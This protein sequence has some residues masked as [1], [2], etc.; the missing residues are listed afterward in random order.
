MKHREKNITVLIDN[1]LGDNDESFSFL[2][3]IAKDFIDRSMSEENHQIPGKRFSIEYTEIT[4][5]VSNMIFNKILG[6]ISRSNSYFDDSVIVLTQIASN[7]FC[8]FSN[9][10]FFTLVHDYSSEME[11]FIYSV[12]HVVLDPCSGFLLNAYRE[13]NQKVD[14]FNNNS[15]DF[16]SEF[17]K[18]VQK[19][20]SMVFEFGTKLY[21][22]MSLFPKGQ[23]TTFLTPSFVSSI[24]YIV[25]PPVYRRNDISC[26]FP[27]R[28]EV[29]LAVSHYQSVKSFIKPPKH[30][31]VD[32]TE[33]LQHWSDLFATITA[34]SVDIRD[35]PLVDYTINEHEESS[36]I[37]FLK[38]FCYLGNQPY[39][40]EF[41]HSIV[42]HIIWRHS[43]ISSFLIVWIQSF[44]LINPE[45]S[46]AVYDGI[47]S[48]FNN[49]CD[50][51]SAQLHTFLHFS[52]RFIEVLCCLPG[53]LLT[54]DEVSVFNTIALLCLCSSHSCIRKC[55]IKLIQVI[56]QFINDHD[57]MTIYSVL[58]KK[59]IIIEKGFVSL[60]EYYPS[61]KLWN[62]P[63]QSMCILDFYTVL[64]GNYEI[65]WQIMLS[66]MF[67]VIFG[68]INPQISSHYNNFIMK[69][70]NNSNNRSLLSSNRCFFINILISL[71]VYSSEEK[72]ETNKIISNNIILEIQNSF[73][74]FYPSFCVLFTSLRNNNFSIILDCDIDLFS[75]KQLA[76]I[77]RGISWNKQFFESCENASFYSKFLLLYQGLCERIFRMWETTTNTFSHRH[78]SIKTMVR[79]ESQL[80]RDF[81]VTSYQVL[82]LLRIKYEKCTGSPYPCI[83]TIFGLPHHEMGTIMNL[84]PILYEI[85][86]TNISDQISDRIHCYSIKTLSL[87]LL[88]FEIPK[89]FIVNKKDVIE[90]FFSFINVDPTILTNS[91]VHHFRLFFGDFLERSVMYNGSAFFV[92]I[93]QYFY[94]FPKSYKN[95]TE[96]LIENWKRP[97]STFSEEY[98]N[99]MHCLYQESGNL[100]ASC[101]F[102]LVQMDKSMKRY[103]YILLG[104]LCPIIL[105]YHSRGASYH[106]HFQMKFFLSN[107]PDQISIENA[108]QISKY[109][110]ESLSFLTE[111]VI[112][113]FI[114]A[115]QNRKDND[116]NRS[117]IVLMPWLD[118]IFLDI[119]QR[120]VSNQT[121]LLFMRY[122]F[123]S[124]VEKLMSVLIPPDSDTEDSIALTI[125]QSLGE[126]CNYTQVIITI[127]DVFC[128]Q[129]NINPSLSVIQSLY[130]SSPDKVISCLTSYLSFLYWI[131]NISKQSTNIHVAT[132]DRSD[133]IDISYIKQT[134]FVLRALVKLSKV[135]ISHII[136]YLPTVFS[137]I[138]IHYSEENYEFF[139][140]IVTQISSFF[141][142]NSPN[143]IQDLIRIHHKDSS[144]FS[145]LLCILLKELM[146]ICNIKKNLEYEYSIEVLR[147][148]ICCGDL[149]I[150][151]K[152]VETFSGIHGFL[153]PTVIA[154]FV[155]SSWIITSAM[156]EVQ[157][158]CE[159]DEEYRYLH[160]ILIFFRSSASLF[161]DRLCL[162][163]YP[164]IFWFSVSFLSY[165][166]RKMSLIFNQALETISFFLEQD[167]LFYFLK[168]LQKKPN[169]DQYLTNVFW[170]YHTPWRDTFPGIG[171]DILGSRCDK[172]NIWLCIRI[173]NLIIQSGYSVLFSNSKKW[174]YTAILSILPWIWKVVTSNLYRFVI[175]SDD[176]KMLKY[177]IESLSSVIEDAALLNNL[178]AILSGESNVFYE[179][180]KQVTIACLNIMDQSDIPYVG[181][182]YVNMFKFGDKYIRIPLYSLISWIIESTLDVNPFLVSI[183]EM[184]NLVLSEY[185]SKRAPFIENL[186]KSLE[187]RSVILQSLPKLYHED[188][189]PVIPLLEKIVVVDI[190]HMYDVSILNECESKCEDINSF[191]PLCPVRG[192][193]N[194][195]ESIRKIR[196]MIAK[197][198]FPP[199]HEWSLLISR[200]KICL[201]EVYSL[202][203][204]D[205]IDNKASK[206]IS[207]ILQKSL[208][209]ILN[210]SST[211]DDEIDDSDIG[212][213]PSPDSLLSIPPKMFIPTIFEVNL[214][215]ND[216]YER[217]TT[218]Q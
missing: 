53:C 46:K 20:R 74:N 160:S 65:L 120:I 104:T 56:H 123:S 168:N 191:I 166:Q 51:S 176:V 143:L 132:F 172:V 206:C 183:H 119:E 66:S 14:F 124:F 114:E 102:Y 113:R 190:P 58:N 7:D 64:E 136:P 96:I 162:S 137:F 23:F 157:T 26:S 116:I 60:F 17:G 130:M 177:T 195:S 2:E 78:T 33:N 32:N 8:Y 187:Y 118:T 9:H 35:E 57:S 209:E 138:S 93:C 147:W 158:E 11:Y 134:N 30:G 174:V 24:Q 71:T 19:V 194:Q 1:F 155:R 211:A 171:N 181:N 83:H 67:S 10:L 4:N 188:S 18:S 59:R 207:M 122:T 159:F 169:S 68:S 90:K 133:Q 156:T 216:M 208:N 153:N 210:E 31:I 182:F 52:S 29:L 170:K 152:A 128:N 43:E 202:K 112:D 149:R 108:R 141:G 61:V 164:S 131:H 179:S 213:L 105:A 15:K 94:I 184:L 3:L 37:K 63:L 173:F 25:V 204:R 47:I 76:F 13:K 103:S 89:S 107:S 109:T 200:S 144:Q 140:I 40:N 6:A 161:K 72:C 186:K 54:Y 126:R 81:L 99:N 203:E 197:I 150:S 5:T 196:T 178:N 79:D 62:D 148:A 100:I 199:F 163:N 50:F 135:S 28:S 215:G 165:N 125:W 218:D 27:E 38:L 139:L 117:F 70:L 39:S 193:I 110:Q 167:G 98:I 142:K 217:E 214:I 198:V 73:E 154:L 201:F 34:H 88:C 55:S 86:D 92:A 212:S 21:N 12:S 189:I 185:S 84:F 42:G 82:T 75:S 87:W 145:S 91:L 85:S 129:P 95:H 48:E 121:D 44:L 80:I 205:F 175:T 77:L 111:S 16:N 106:Q 22:T 36:I 49:I 41:A 45:L 69:F 146:P 101:L 151:A 115:H 127:V 192:E 97:V 180:M